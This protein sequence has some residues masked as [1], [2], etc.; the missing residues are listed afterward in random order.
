VS[1]YLACFF[2]FVSRADLF[3]DIYVHFSNSPWLERT[4]DED[5]MSDETWP[6]GIIF[7]RALYWAAMTLTTVGHVDQIDAATSGAQWEF[8]VGIVIMI[9][10]MC[11]PPRACAARMCRTP[12]HAAARARREYLRRTHR[13]S[14]T[15]WVVALVV[16]RG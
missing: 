15:R 9:T 6:T 8:A 13:P 2:V 12:P 7:L 1:D 5:D 3:G 10:A 4:I 11:T 14:L 16:R